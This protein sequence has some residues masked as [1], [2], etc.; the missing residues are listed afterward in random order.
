MKNKEAHYSKSPLDQAGVTQKIQTMIVMKHT[1]LSPILTVSKQHL[2]HLNLWEN[3]VRLSGMTQK[4]G[5][6]EYHGVVEIGDNIQHNG[7]ELDL[8]RVTFGCI[9]VIVD[10][11]DWLNGDTFPPHLVHMSLSQNHGP[12]EYVLVMMA[13]SQEWSTGEGQLLWDDNFTTTLE[14]Q[15]NVTVRGDGSKHH[16]SV[17]NFFGLG[18]MAKYEKNGNASYAKVAGKK[19][20]DKKLLK[21]LVEQLEQTFLSMTNT[22]NN[23]IPGVVAMG[24]CIPQALVDISARIGKE[25][26]EKMVSFL[27]GMVTA[28]VC[29]NAQ[30]KQVHFEK[31]CSFTLIGS[32]FAT[33]RINTMGEFVFEFEWKQDEFI[34]PSAPTTP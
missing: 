29:K 28:F 26:H 24:Q 27:E 3:T 34:I 12:D 2:L 33:D 23:I 9:L 19:G 14:R 25:D 15:M 1:S 17:G 21:K 5:K 10:I 16:Q 4:D 13:G 7:G 8:S 31:D 6:L 11:K 30:T 32:P 18:W 22:L 20:A